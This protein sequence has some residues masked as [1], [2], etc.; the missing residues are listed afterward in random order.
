MRRAIIATVGT[1]VGLVAL[2]DF[3]ANGTVKAVQVA[4]PSSSSSTSSGSSASGSSASASSAGTF[5][6]EEVP[7]QYGEIEVAIT[8]HDGKITAVDFPVNTSD[9][10]ESQAIDS[11]AVAIL[12]KEVLAAQSLH[13]DSVSGATYTSDAF[14]Q[15]LQAALVKAGK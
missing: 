5:T 12:T 10:P 2:L 4:I 15:S 7:Y 3:K 9:D 14:A 8:V 11:Q 13:V 1:V 6:G